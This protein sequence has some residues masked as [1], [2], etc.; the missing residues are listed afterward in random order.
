M[1]VVEREREELL[2]RIQWKKKVWST[3]RAVFMDMEYK[4]VDSPEKRNCYAMISKI[5]YMAE[6][7]DSGGTADG[8]GRVPGAGDDG[9]GS[10]ARGGR[11]GG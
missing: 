9:R 3:Y 10:V 5:V 2:E 4:A 6:K 8:G 1:E 11:D 7:T